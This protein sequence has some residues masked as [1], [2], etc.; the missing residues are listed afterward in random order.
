MRS[1]A[2]FQVGLKVLLVRQGRPLIVRERVKP[3][4]WEL[5]GG[6]FD[7]GEETVAP[8]TRPRHRSPRCVRRMRPDEVP[9]L[10]LNAK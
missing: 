6:R 9:A 7:V 2:M 5:P 10:V 3:Q 4:F 1:V 8:A